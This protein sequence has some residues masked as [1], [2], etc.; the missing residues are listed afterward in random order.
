MVRLQLGVDRPAAGCW[1]P[2]QVIDES[3]R[4]SERRQWVCGRSELV[5]DANDNL[6]D[7]PLLGMHSQELELWECVVERLEEVVDR[8]L[9]GSG[10]TSLVAEILHC[11]E[12]R[13]KLV[14]ERFEEVHGR[15]ERLLDE[16]LSGFGEP[17]V[18]VESLH[19]MAERLDLAV[20][21]LGLVVEMVCFAAASLERVAV[22]QRSALELGGLEWATEGLASVTQGPVWL[23]DGSVHVACGSQ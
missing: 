20:G 4:V 8:T 14:G 16:P 1:T 5:S 19:R 21:T 9:S 3:D 22:I 6:L 10:G 13:L 18:V 7:T 17:P 15:L 2:E 23:T 11:M 12:G